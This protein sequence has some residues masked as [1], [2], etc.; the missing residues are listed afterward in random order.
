MSFEPA[1]AWALAPAALVPELSAGRVFISGRLP[2]T[3]VR[4]VRE[5]CSG[6]RMVLSSMS[7]TTAAPTASKAA[8]KNASSRFRG[9]SGNTGF[10]AGRARSAMRMA[11]FW[12]PALMLA[13]LILPHQL[14]V[15]G[16][17]GVGL[18]LR[19]PDTRRSAR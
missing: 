11:E 8:N 18:A 10:S 1:A 7:L 14:F 2:M 12:K 3:S 6:S 15:E 17:V 4:S 16:L 19:R 13:S 5:A 9:M